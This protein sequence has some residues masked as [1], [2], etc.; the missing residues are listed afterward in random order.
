MNA[1]D[2][3]TLFASLDADGD[4]AIS[5]RALMNLACL[6]T[7]LHKQTEANDGFGRHTDDTLLGFQCPVRQRF[8]RVCRPVRAAAWSSQSSGLSEKFWGVH[9][10]KGVHLVKSSGKM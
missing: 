6:N 5:F 7:K 4:G 8:G 9:F 1:A 2:T 3:W 10:V